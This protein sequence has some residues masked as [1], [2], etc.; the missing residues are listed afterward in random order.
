MRLL[1]LVEEPQFQ[2]KRN[3]HRLSTHMADVDLN[4]IRYDRVQLSCDLGL[5]D[6]SDHL[7]GHLALL[8]NQKRGNAADSILTSGFLCIVYIELA[9]FGTTRILVG[10]FLNDRSDHPAG[11]APSG[12][13]I[14]ENGY[15]C[16]QHFD[17]E[18]VIGQGNR[19]AHSQ[20]C[21]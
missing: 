17:A 6:R 2:T 1:F 12:P 14:N 13:K 20:V 4:S 7:V 5:G 9:D 11:A 19:L 10:Q 21:R 8:E 16:A 15:L 3:I 18:V